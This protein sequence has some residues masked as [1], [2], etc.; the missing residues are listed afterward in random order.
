[1]RLSLLAAATSALLMLA[2]MAHGAEPPKAPDEAK[3]QLHWGVKIPLRDGVK[4]N[5]TVYTPKGQA[6]P[7]PC[8]FTLTPYISQTYNE[9]GVYFAAHGLPFLIVDVRGRGNSEG[10]FH[11]MIQEAKDGY[12]VVEW[13]AKQSYC[14]GKVSMWGGSYAGYDQWATAKER[15]PHLSTIVPVAA[16]YAGMDFPMHANIASPYLLQWLFFT[17]GHTGQD[18][19]FGDTPY[20]NQLWKDR[21]EKGQSF[22]G[23]SKAIDGFDPP[24]LRAWTGHPTLGPYY[25]AYNPSEAQYRALTIPILTLTGSYDGDQLG[26]LAHYRNYMKVA[27]PEARDRHYLIIGP[28]DHP[29]TR[30]PRAKIGGLT[31]GPASLVDLPALHTQWYNWTMAGGPKPDFLKKH[32]A[33]YVMGAETWRYADT[34]EGVTAEEKPYLLEST[35][36]AQKLAGSGALLAG[37]AAKGPPDSYVYDPRDTSTAALE[38]SITSPDVLT[39]TTMVTAQDTKQLVYH[40]PPFA[41]DTEISGF[42]RL[43][44]WIAI[45]QPDTDFLATVYEITADGH[46]IQLTSDMVR[47][48]YRQSLKTQAL[49][50]T[51]EPLKYDFS[52]FMFVSRKVA[53]GSRLRL[54]IGPINSISAQKNYNSGKPVSLE[55]MADARAVK[56]TLVHDKAHPSTL[57][58]PFG[59]P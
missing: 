57:Y 59:Q 30:T 50:A 53:A 46:S 3:I 49:I 38:A 31:F 23:L 16:P 1:M 20:W 6:A 13:L 47:A 54:I 42:F 32:V 33:Y 11:P 19:I 22:A 4:L 56:V 51:R 25:D 5:A 40:S 21:F 27:T 9:R 26:A 52:S 24:T 35:G 12:D 29:A 7:A 36:D 34:L 18:Q 39:D 10:V 58:V 28:W 2:G 45:D 43:S 15:P 14:N 8:I 37:A 48:R 17:A 41:K 55:T 44:A